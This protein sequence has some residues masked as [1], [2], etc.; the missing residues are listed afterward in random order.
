[1]TAGMGHP[2]VYIFIQVNLHRQLHNKTA[3]SAITSI[4]NAIN[5]IQT[6]AGNGCEKKPK[7]ST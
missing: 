1:M 2:W 3:Y 7:K 5:D 6:R 4:Q